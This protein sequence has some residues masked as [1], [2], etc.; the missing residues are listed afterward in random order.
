MGEQQLEHADLAEGWVLLPEHE[1][2]ALYALTSRPGLK[3]AL[4]FPL[5]QHDTVG[6]VTTPRGSGTENDTVGAVRTME[7]RPHFYGSRQ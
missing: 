6:A 7:P 1:G 2:V 4:T 3:Q 5:P